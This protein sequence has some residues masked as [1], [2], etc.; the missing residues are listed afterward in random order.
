MDKFT[1]HIKDSLENYEMPYNEAD[2]NKLKKKL[3]NNKP[4][5]FLNSLQRHVS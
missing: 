4:K 1:Q 2:W 5:K 3:P